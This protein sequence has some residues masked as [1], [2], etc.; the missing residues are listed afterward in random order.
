MM[1]YYYEHPGQKY[2]EMDPYLVAYQHYMDSYSKGYYEEAA[3]YGVPG[4]LLTR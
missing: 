1:R 4:Q 3:S 2:P